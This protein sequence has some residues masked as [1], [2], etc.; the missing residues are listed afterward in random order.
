MSIAAKQEAFE[1]AAKLKNQFRN[2]EED[3]VDFLDSVLESTRAKEAAVRKETTEQLEAFRKQRED[4]DR[5]LR[6]GEDVE[7]AGSPTEELES[8]SVG[9]KRRRKDKGPASGVKLR[10]SSSTQDQSQSA[11]TLSPDT[12]KTLPA[13]KELKK[14]KAGQELQ[15]NSPDLAPK[16]ASHPSAP[17]DSKKSQPSP[18]KPS[19]GLGLAGYSSD[20]DI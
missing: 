9:K 8:W 14:E 11:Q 7:K 10:K 12:T 4:A 15:P 3:E 13:F 1:E 18:N 6:D 17:P 16:A 5:A 2:L 20:E 19:V